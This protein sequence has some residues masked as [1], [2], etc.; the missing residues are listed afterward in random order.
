MSNLKDFADNLQHEVVTDMAESYF[1]DRKNLE[2]MI[3]AF[4]QLVQDFREEAHKLSEAAGE[5]HHLLLDRQNARDFYISLDI[6]PSCIPFPEGESSQSQVSPPFALTVAGR[7]EKS[8]CRAYDR[9][10]RTADEYLNGRYYN[11]PDHSG[12]KRLTVHY[13]R[14]RALAEYI[15]GEVERVN[16]NV[17]TTG[18]LRFVK[19]M[20][21]EQAE[22]E[23][24]IG[25]AC[26]LEG[27]DLDEEMKFS[28]IDFDELKLPVVQDLPRL[29]MVKRAIKQFCKESYVDRKH[30]IKEVIESMR[31]AKD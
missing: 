15:N 29:S 5:L 2:D 3:E 9:L 12:R 26:L 22:R 19:R 7:Y 27:C 25:S 28:P 8:V 11:D 16:K 1:G 21:P 14:L 10:Q 20:D 13:L 24:M 4:H 17:S 31:K 30:E 23:D 6:V 18:A